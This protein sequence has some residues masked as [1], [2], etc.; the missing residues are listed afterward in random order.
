MQD[1]AVQPS[2]KTHSSG[3]SRLSVA[4]TNHHPTTGS[5]NAHADSDDGHQ[6]VIAS[7]RTQI[8][9]LVTQVNQLNGKLVQSYDRISDLEDNIHVSSATLRAS[10]VK[11]SQLELE[12]AQHLAALNT[13]LL[14]EKA[15]VT[16]ELTRLMERATEEAAQRGQAETARADI[17]KDLDDLS[18]N[19]FDQ[20]NNMVAEARL[21][22]AIS[23]QKVG[24]A[25]AA[26]RGAEEAVALMQEQM[27]ALQAEKEASTRIAE[28]LRAQIGADGKMRDFIP[29]GSGFASPRLL[30]LHSPY[31][32]YLGMLDHLRHL[33]ATNVSP[34]NISGVLNLPF[35]ARLL[36]EDSWVKS[37]I[38]V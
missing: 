22:R 38:C 4:S 17:E 14:V 11:I 2:E 15:H 10:T 19:L 6:L 7:L 33:H 31:H 27:Q 12:R 5:S 20:A 16:A 29:A 25:E 9:D 8:Q 28:Q 34:P 32:E 21:A 24:T 1:T 37:Y 36:T 23:E 3:T 18:A 30:R 26:L 35:I 13:G